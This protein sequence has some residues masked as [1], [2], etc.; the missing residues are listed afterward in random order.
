[1]SCPSYAPESPI[2]IDLTRVPMHTHITGDHIDD[3]LGPGKKGPGRKRRL[4]ADKKVSDIPSLPEGLRSRSIGSASGL[5]AVGVPDH[6]E[7]VDL[8]EPVSLDELVDLDEPVDLDEHEPV[9][10][11]PEPVEHTHITGII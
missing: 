10:D 8:E 9:V 1:M 3:P 7:P 5:G 4:G 11:E 6:E 2:E